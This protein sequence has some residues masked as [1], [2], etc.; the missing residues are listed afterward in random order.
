MNLFIVEEDHRLLLH[1]RIIVGEWVY[2]VVDNALVVVV[3]KLVQ[4]NER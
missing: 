1:L 3:V 4:R 2:Y